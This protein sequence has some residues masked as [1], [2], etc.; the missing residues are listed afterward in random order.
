MVEFIVLVLMR[1]SMIKSR[2]VSIVFVTLGVD[3]IL[4][5]GCRI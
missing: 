3:I 1:L 5:H 4:G 2:M